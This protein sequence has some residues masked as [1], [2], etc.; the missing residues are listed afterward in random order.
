[1]VY[2]LDSR[3]KKRIII[4]IAVLIVISIIGGRILNSMDEGFIRNVLIFI[5]RI[6]L[7]SAFMLFGLLWRCLDIS[8]VIKSIATVFC[9]VVTILFP[10]FFGW[11]SISSFSIDYVIPFVLTGI[12]GTCAAVVLSKYL[13]CRFLRFLGRE[14]LIIMG[15]HQFVRF[16]LLF[17][18]P[19]IYNSKYIVLIYL[20][21][22]VML[23][24]ILI[25]VLN[26]FVPFFIGKEEFPLLK[27]Y[28]SNL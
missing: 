20:I 3:N 27:K 4:E 1:V 10:F 24:A 2:W 9:L 5:S 14:S 19:D 7:S 8:K 12:T 16:A 22:V 25:P 6:A 26:R 17:R 13:D 11:E 15:T 21:G 23:D 28:R 18:F